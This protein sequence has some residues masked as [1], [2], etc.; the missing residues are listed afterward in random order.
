MIGKLRDI[1]VKAVIASLF[2]DIGGTFLFF[3]L[4]SVIG[5]ILLSSLG[6]DPDELKDYPE[7]TTFIIVSS[8]AG[9]LFSAL[10]GYVSARISGKAEMKNALATGALSVLIGLVLFAAPPASPRSWLDLLSLVLI[11]P[12]AL[13]GGYACMK[14]KQGKGASPEK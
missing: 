9:L 13:L 5:A 4:F 1:S 12:F 10:G 11:I 8:F 7:T 14:G 6:R 2:V 3:F